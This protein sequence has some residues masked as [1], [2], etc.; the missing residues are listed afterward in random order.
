M[1]L[2]PPFIPD[3]SEFLLLIMTLIGDSAVFLL[4]VQPL[5]AYSVPF[6]LLMPPYFPC[7]FLAFCYILVI[8]RPYAAY[9]AFHF[10]FL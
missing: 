7:I 9:A 8:R 3:S 2:M 10:R 4:P 5:N 6:L 1:L